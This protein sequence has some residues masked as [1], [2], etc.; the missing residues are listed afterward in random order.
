MASAV[1]SENPR[2]PSAGYQLFAAHLLTVWGLALSNLFLGLNLLVTFARARRLRI[3]WQRTA[4]ILVPLGFYVLFLGG[5]VV[6]S[7]DPV[8]SAREMGEVLSLVTLLLALLWV[9]GEV[10][11][12]RLYDL[13]ILMTVALAVYGIGQYL[14]TDYGPLEKRIRGPFSHYMTFSGVLLLGDFLLFARMMTARRWRRPWL[15]LAFALLNT[16]LFLTLT[17]GAWVAAAVLLTL[18]VALRVRR[19]F[20]VYLA[21]AVLS[22]VLF[23]SYAPDSWTGRIRS[24][25]DPSDGSNYDRLCMA[26]AGLHMIAERPLFGI[27]PSMVERRYPIYRHPTAPRF[28]VS[29]LHNTFL[30]LAAERGLLSLGAYLWLMAAALAVAYRGY[31]REGGHGGPR[32]DLYLGMILAVIGF[33]LAGFFEANWLDTEV[34][35]LVLFLLAVPCCLTAPSGDPEV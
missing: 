30:Q 35:R 28:E 19:Y 25:V 1:R 33:N 13:L 16:A 4:P 29:H 21:A 15:W 8:S 31:R 5:A 6:N 22:G 23:F 9:R 10:R 14:V 17:R 26:Q 2:R 18:F 34:Q 11:V 12:R 32:A 3:D 27:G 20:V 7:I 24:I